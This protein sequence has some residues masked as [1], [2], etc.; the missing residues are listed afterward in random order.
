M[1]LFFSTLTLFMSVSVLSLSGDAN[2]ANECV[3]W[4][5]AV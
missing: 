4:A 2:D 1:E 3:V 5:Y